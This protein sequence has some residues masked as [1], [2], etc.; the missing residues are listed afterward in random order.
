MLL[1]I[2]SFLQRLGLENRQGNQCNK[3]RFILFFLSDISYDKS[4]WLILYFDAF[5]FYLISFTIYW[6]KIL[7]TLEVKKLLDRNFVAGISKSR[8]LWPIINFF[9]K[10]LG[11]NSNNLVKI[12]FV[13]K[14]K[15]WSNFQDAIPD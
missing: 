1:K 8:F 3:R 15:G 6:K 4:F 13:F 9:T 11:F 10:H 5:Y 2:H 12:V 7:F 14:L